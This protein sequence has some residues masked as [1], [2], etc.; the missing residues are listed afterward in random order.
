MSTNQN[1]SRRTQMQRALANEMTRKELLEFLND[2][3]SKKEF[4]ELMKLKNKIGSLEPNSGKEE[5]VSSI[6]N[7]QFSAYSK[8]GILAAACLFLLGILGFYFLFFF[9]EET[10]FETVK[11]VTTGSC[12]MK[13]EKRSLL[14]K[15]G[16]ESLCDYK[17]EGELGLVVRLL[18]DSEFKI[19]SGES[20][21]DLELNSGI[22]IFT[23]YKKNPSLKVTAQVHSLYSEL[24]GT[25][26]VLTAKRN[27]EKDRILV[28]EGAVR[29]RGIEQKLKIT[30]DIY[31]EYSV[32]EKEKAG[33]SSEIR[34]EVEK[35]QSIELD[36]YKKLS[37]D[38]RKTVN[39]DETNHNRETMALVQKEFSGKNPSSEP[40]Y[41]IVL[42]DKKAYLGTLEEEEK[43]Y[44]LTDSKG[45]VTRID[46]TEVL[47][48]ELFHE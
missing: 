48:L 45:N 44:V 26:L 39:G 41:K 9:R 43:I 1:Q 33:S 34:I 32:F 38:S 47:E 28:L 19:F 5:N 29:A 14:L 15:S 3:R 11:S 46:K 10:R 7:F 20:G 6:R 30:A 36:R 8:N 17:I 31:A 35:I 16:K 24:L 42:K 22:V 13:N 21:I 18:P 23:T 27:Q 40:V 4:F 2:P 37:R 12:E 25:T